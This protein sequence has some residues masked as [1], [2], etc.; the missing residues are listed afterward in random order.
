[1][2]TIRS[3]FNIDVSKNRSN[4]RGQALPKPATIG[5]DGR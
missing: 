3:G 2:V 5:D 1:M 4:L